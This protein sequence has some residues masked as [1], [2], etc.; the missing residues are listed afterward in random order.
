[1]KKVY[2][3]FILIFALAFSGCSNTADQATETTSKSTENTT[4]SLQET[5]TTVQSSNENSD[6]QT[7]QDKMRVYESE[8]G[9]IEIPVSP[10][11]IVVLDSFAIGSILK[12]GGNVVGYEK[13]AATNP[14]YTPFLENATLV[15]AENLEQILALDPDLII[16]SSTDKNY[17]ELSEIAPTL[18]FTYGRL[19]YLESITE[20][21]SLIGKTSEAQAWVNDFQQRAKEAGIAI[22]E[23]Y[24][25]NVT[26]SVMEAFGD[27]MYLYGDNW[28]R[29]T[30]I[31][32]QEMGLKMTEAVK[33]VALK[34]GYYA[35]SPEVI[36]EY[37]ADLMV[38]CYFEGSNMAF[39]ETDTWKNIP[40]V[41]NKTV[42]VKEAE[43]FYHTDSLT[44]DYQLKEIKAFFLKDEH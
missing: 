16:T 1:M 40:A 35:I 19:S 9:N 27:S 30:Q 33:S 38:L 22:K 18:S 25:E 14:H 5:S 36:P 7:N 6:N 11:R 4:E 44:L 29:G 20:Y 15:N 42:L 34:D 23:K 8:N 28:G 41:K 26:V 2:I 17:K 37:T 24:G 21:A 13:W 32:Y 43:S 3:V 39:L 10:Q 31:L 12:F